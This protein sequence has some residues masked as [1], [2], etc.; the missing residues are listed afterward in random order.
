MD[1]HFAQYLAHD[2]L[3]VHNLPDWTFRFNRRRRSLG[4]CFYDDHRIELSLPFVTRNDEA[5]VRDTILHEIAHALA[6]RR[7]G[8]GPAWKAIC[9][10][11][12]AK[13][14][15]CDEEAVMPAGRWRAICPGCGKQFHRYRR[16]KRNTNYA[17]RRCGPQRGAIRF[18][19]TFDSPTTG[20]A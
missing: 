7:A 9:L 18:M 19:L 1:A 6:G 15:R 8:H 11:L 20:A 16:P 5:A 4:L 3:R 13:P 10:R 14:Q 12:G 2:L 17:C